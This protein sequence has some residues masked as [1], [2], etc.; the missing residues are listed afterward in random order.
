L[1]GTPGGPLNQAA[2]AVKIDTTEKARPPVG[3]LQADVVFEEMV[4]GRLTRLMAIF[5]SQLPGDVGP[6]R[7]ARSSDIAFLGELGRPLFAWSGANR[8]FVQLIQAANLVDVGPGAA[9]D[10]YRRQSGRTAPANLFAT[11]EQ[12]RAIGASLD[13][14]AAATDPPAMFGYRTHGEPLAGPGLAPAAG[15]ETNAELTTR[16]RWDYDPATGLYVRTQNGTPHVDV[17]G[18]QVAAVNVLIRFTPYVDS[19]YVDTTGAMVPEAAAIG[20]GD[21][22]LI[23]QG[24]V[25]P[26][27]WS[28]AAVDG[29]TTYTLLDGTPLTLTPGNT[30]VEVLPPSSGAAF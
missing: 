30:W 2:L 12:L 28:K 23:T 16:V 8:D 20:E 14:T 21:A 10:A 3:L 19:G 27:H 29:P 15:F 5:H 24:Q 25:I 11:P 1:L 18:A 6:V 26:G 4:E 9:G 13:G 17:D 7:S 22:A